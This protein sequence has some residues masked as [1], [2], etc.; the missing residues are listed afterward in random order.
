MISFRFYLRHLKFIIGA[1]DGIHNFELFRMA[2]VS[3]KDVD[4][5][6]VKL[7]EGGNSKEFTLNSN[8]ALA[9]KHEDLT[10]LAASIATG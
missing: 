8:A 5:F 2:L 10:Q 6:N 4:K 1:E 3:A 7:V 9:P